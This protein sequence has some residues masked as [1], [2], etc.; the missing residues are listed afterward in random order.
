MESQRIILGI[1]LTE[2]R[3]LLGEYA[4]EK[5]PGVVWDQ[6]VDLLADDDDESDDC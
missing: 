1:Q 6:T 5:K 2:V 3:G 4:E